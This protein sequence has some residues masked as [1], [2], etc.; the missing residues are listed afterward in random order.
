MSDEVQLAD[1]GF[2]ALIEKVQRERGFACASYKQSCLRRRVNTRMRLRGVPTFSAYAAILDRD[3]RE[4]DK[5]MDAL[6]INVT[7]FFRNAAIWESIADQVVGPIWRTDLEDIRVWSAGC[8]TGEEAYSMAILF[9]RVAATSGMLGQIDRV[10]VQGTDVDPRAIEFAREADYG[11]AS[12]AEIPAELRSRYFPERPPFTPATGVRRMVH[13]D[14][15]DLLAGGYPSEPQDVI[16]CRNVLIYFD[17]A[18]Q[19]QVL[20][21]FREALRPG[22]YL[23]LG[24]VESLLGATRQHFEPIVQRARI[25]RRV[26]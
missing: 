23:I 15:A 4:F 20:E 24:K 13:F 19:E 21:S 18:V 1:D 25:F 22:G 3:S 16:I 8:A 17:R 6:T 12:L 14:V 11:A 10:R 5:L 9:H 26:R 2:A 7:R